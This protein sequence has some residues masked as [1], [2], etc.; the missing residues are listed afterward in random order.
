MA[1]RTTVECAQYPR[2]CSVDCALVFMPFVQQCAVLL[3]VLFHVN[4]GTAGAAGLN[5]SSLAR[6]TAVCEHQNKTALS[7][8]IRH[9]VARN[10]TI[11][12]LRV[13]R[14]ALRVQ[15]HGFQGAPYHS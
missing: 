13:Q 2:A 9:L 4:G 6:F 11:D 14:Y 8:R 3:P 7:L 1:S 12:A 10:C 15:R 5:A